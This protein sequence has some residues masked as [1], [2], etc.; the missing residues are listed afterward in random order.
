MLLKIIKAYGKTFYII[1]ERVYK[2]AKI[3]IL[4]LFILVASIFPFIFSKIVD[5]MIETSGN[6]NRQ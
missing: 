2:S 5:K 3:L 1:D 6:F 4:L